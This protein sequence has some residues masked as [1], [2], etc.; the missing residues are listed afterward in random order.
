MRG[1]RGRA[2]WRE[3]DRRIMRAFYHA[4][5]MTHPKSEATDWSRFEAI[6]KRPITV[7]HR[8]APREC[9]E[10]SI[11]GFD[12][13]LALGL[14]GIEFDVRMSSDGVPVVIHD[15][16]LDRTTTG[17]GP[18]DEQ[19]LAMIRSLE[20]RGATDVDTP[21]RVPTLDEVLDRY[22]T[23]AILHVELKTSAPGDAAF[24]LGRVVGARLGQSSNAL[25]SL[26]MSFEPDALRGFREAASEVEL[27]YLVLAEDLQ[28]TRARE[29]LLA[30]AR[31]LDAAFVGVPD[32]TITPDV[33]AYVHRWS[34]QLVTWPNV[35]DVAIRVGLHSRVE[36]METDDPQKLLQRLSALPRRRTARVN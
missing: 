4:A 8:G 29:D 21:L 10:N 36:R 12:R 15:A 11:A 31:D 35:D 14:D 27:A 24:E 7:G 16:T 3:L 23:R 19:N 33:A 32:S 6:F 26:V 5:E 9:P 30:R 18:V 1:L 20:I 22:A 34:M 25:P 2:A 17:T 13:A 28:G